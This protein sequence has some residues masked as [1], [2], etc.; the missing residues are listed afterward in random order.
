MAKKIKIDREYCQ[1]ID[2]MLPLF[3]KLFANGLRSGVSLVDLLDLLAD[4]FPSPLKEE[5]KTVRERISEGNNF[6]T[7]FSEIYSRVPTKRMLAFYLSI[8]GGE[9]AGNI[10]VTL[11]FAELDKIETGLF[12]D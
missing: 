6:K 3:T 1:K 9:Q 7:I 2:E 8:I 4:A 11:G 10:E 12:T 5:I